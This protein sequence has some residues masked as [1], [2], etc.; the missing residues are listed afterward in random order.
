M[1]LDQTWDEA[2]WI[3]VYNQ[4][5]RHRSELVR[6]FT[7]YLRRKEIAHAR[8]IARLQNII[9]QLEKELNEYREAGN[10]SR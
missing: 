6:G 2:K 10:A 7:R 3:A 9:K 1:P 4:E 5:S 8:E